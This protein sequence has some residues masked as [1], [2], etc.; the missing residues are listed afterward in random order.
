MIDQQLVKNLVGNIK[1]LLEHELR[2]GN[3]IVET[4]EGWPMKRVNIWL[5]NDFRKSYRTQYQNLKFRTLDDPH[6]WR[7]EYSDE[8]NQEFIATQF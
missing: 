7:N 2:C 3:Q 8:E 1:S 6:Y 4:S 5:K